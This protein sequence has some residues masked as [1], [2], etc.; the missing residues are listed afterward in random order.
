MIYNARV[1]Q[2]TGE[3]WDKVALRLSTAN[4]QQRGE[5][6]QILPWY[7]D[8]EQPIIIQRQYNQMKSEAA[9]LEMRVAEDEAPMP[10]SSG[11]AANY[12]QVNANQTNFEFA[13]SIPYDIP[14]D[15]KQYTINIQDFNLPALFEYYTVP[16]LDRDAFL[17]ARITGWEKYNLLPGEINLF[18]EGTYV[19]KS[20][21]DVRNTEDTLDLSLGRDKGIVITRIKLQDLTSERTIGANQRETRTWEISVRNNK[22]QPVDLKIED[23]IPVSMNKDIEIETTEISGGKLEPESGIITWKQKIAPGIEN[24]I[25]VSFA[26]KY[27]KDKRVFID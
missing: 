7:L 16:R 1:Y 21:L 22:R 13:I 5:K 3:S 11:T 18:F 4:P 9:P 25:R 27:P 24:K 10:V 6:P 26:V 23:Q 20:F 12:T 19:G 15:N 2:N 17:L 14:S 8:F